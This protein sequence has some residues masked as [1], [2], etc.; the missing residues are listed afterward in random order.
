MPLFVPISESKFGRLGLRRTG[1]RIES[2]AT[3]STEIDFYEI[4]VRLV[5]VFWRPWEQFF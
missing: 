4:R 5:V 3:V 1:L 2:I